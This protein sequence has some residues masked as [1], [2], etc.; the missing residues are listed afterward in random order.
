MTGPLLDVYPRLD[1]TLT[2][3]SG[4]WLHTADGRQILDLYGGH[5]VTP[6]GHAHPRIIGVT[7]QA[8]RTL[9]FYSNSLQM[10]VQ[11]RAARAL[12][13]DSA[14]A[15]VH[16]VN[17]GTEANEAALHLA[18][19]L[20][21]RRVV[22]AFRCGFHGRTAASLAASGLQSYH[23]R[24][25]L[26]IA[27]DCQRFV[28]FGD[29]TQLDQIDSDVAGVIC[30]SIPSLA[31][32]LMPPDGYYSRLAQ[33]CRDVGAQL[34]FDE[35]QGGVGR[36]GHWFAHQLFGIEPNMVTLAKG[37]ANG[38][39]AGALLVDRAIAEQVT[40][41]E[42]GTTFGG[43][44]LACT[45]IEAVATCVRESGLLRRTSEIFQLLQR[46]LAELPLRIRGAGCLIGIQSQLPA[47]VLRDQLLSHEILVGTSAEPNTI[48]LL[49]PYTVSDSELARFCAAIGAILKG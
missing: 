28:E 35:V 30:E 16:F 45:L 48:R 1:L 44:P 43:G 18:R 49:P 9:D 14:L 26:P 8:Q 36:V 29:G 21:G 3:A 46:E 38:Y 24:L 2:A 7:S 37:I 19:R 12:L 23:D 10:P 20:T 41:G 25:A 6:L 33:R 13:A 15:A 34:I 22:V 11:Q 31:G 40:H 27:A 42:L 5:A 17:S 47:K 32:V 4:C 39:P